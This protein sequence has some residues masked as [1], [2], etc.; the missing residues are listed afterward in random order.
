MVQKKIQKNTK[1]FW[2]CFFLILFVAIFVRFFQVTKF[3]PSLYDEE[4]ALGYDAYSILKTGKDHPGNPP[5]LVAFESYGDYKPA[6]YFYLIVPSIA[7]FGLNEFAV[8]LPA[9]IAGVFIVV[10]VG[11][12]VK[13]ISGN[14]TKKGLVLQLI[15]MGVAAISPWAVMFSRAAWEANVATC[16]IV[17]GVVFG[18][19]HLRTWKWWWAAGSFFSFALSMY[20][21][22][23]A[24]V[25]APFLALFLFLWWL[26]EKKLLKFSFKKNL[27]QCFFAVLFFLLLFSPIFFSLP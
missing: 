27:L 11:L 23:S 14:E 20:T 19:L 15:A 7:V 25:I 24:R 22:H 16:F 5:P 21:Y 12:I 13:E 1:W 26:A 4:I 17:W 18:L 6:L 9:M 3:P 10:G 8:R 2:P